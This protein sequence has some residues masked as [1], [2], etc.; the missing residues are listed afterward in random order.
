MIDNAF[1]CITVLGTVTNGRAVAKSFGRTHLVKFHVNVRQHEGVIGF[2][3][4]YLTDTQAD[5]NTVAAL[6][7]KPGVRVCLSGNLLAMRSKNLDGSI[8]DKWETLRV[9]TLTPIPATER[10]DLDTQPT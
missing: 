3:C 8:K 9:N 4:E 10:V 5:A 7:N 2:G 1:V 6:L